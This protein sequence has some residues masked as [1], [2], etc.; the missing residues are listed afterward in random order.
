MM[1]TFGMVLPVAFVTG[2]ALRKSMPLRA[3]PQLPAAFRASEM[4]VWERSDIFLRVPVRVRLLRSPVY[5]AVVFLPGR[6]F[7]RPDLLA[8]WVPG[9]QSVSDALPDNA[10][11]LGAFNSSGTFQLPQDADGLGGMLVLYSL[12]DHEIVDWSKPIVFH[13][14]KP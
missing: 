3:T 11:L 13:E 10:V 5:F 4:P 6:G 14:P 8:Y 9:T 2:I 1:I 12:A 7:A